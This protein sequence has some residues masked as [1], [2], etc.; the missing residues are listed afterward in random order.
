[1]ITNSQT[2]YRLALHQ[3]IV[4]EL[5]QVRLWSLY[6]HETSNANWKFVAPPEINPV[7][8]MLP[9]PPMEREDATR[10]EHTGTLHEGRCVVRV[11]LRS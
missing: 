1:M 8:W 3:R 4:S 2:P 9:L 5:S 10:R 6:T 7:L 11:V